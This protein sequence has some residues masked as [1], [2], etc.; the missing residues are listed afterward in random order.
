MTNTRPYLAEDWFIAMTPEQQYRYEERIG[1]LCETGPILDWQHDLAYRQ[2][3]EV[4]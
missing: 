4:K 3:M 2:A 1:N